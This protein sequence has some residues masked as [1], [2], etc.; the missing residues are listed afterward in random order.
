[1]EKNLRIPTILLI[2]LSDIDTIN[3]TIDEQY[4][5]LNCCGKI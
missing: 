3:L 1:M 2:F 5:I 4:Y